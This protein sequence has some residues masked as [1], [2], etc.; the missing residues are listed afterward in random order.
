[1]RSGWVGT[2]VELSREEHHPE[3]QHQTQPHVFA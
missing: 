1:M 3:E 2:H